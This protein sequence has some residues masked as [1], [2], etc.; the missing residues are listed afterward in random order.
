MSKSATSHYTGML[1]GGIGQY[2]E[3]AVF[4]PS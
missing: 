1:R 2:G 3:L 4:A